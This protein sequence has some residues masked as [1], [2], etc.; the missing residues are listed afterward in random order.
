MMPLIISIVGFS[1]SGKTR[2]IE[3]MIPILNL[4]G[5]AVGVIKHAGHGFSLDRPE[6]DSCKMQEAGAEGVVLVGSGQIGFLG[7]ID[8]SDPLLVDR[9]EQTFF[10]D[11]DI[12]LTEGFKKGDKPKIVVLTRGQEEQLLKEMGGNI[13]ATVGEKPVRSDWMHFSPDDPEGLVDAL[14][15]RFLKDRKR[16]AIRVMLDGKNIPMNDFVQEIVRS[17]IMGIL[18]PLKGFKDSRMVEV[19][20]KG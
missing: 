7:K 15:N 16:P 10:S 12:V 6:K 14:D 18:S 8:E 2:L 13:V 5:Y 20:I 4:K 19:K 9:L 11:K 1:K 3:K 17:G